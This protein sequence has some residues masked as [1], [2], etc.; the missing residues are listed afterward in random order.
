MSKLLC[1]LLC[2]ILLLS[3]SACKPTDKTEENPSNQD[4][5]TGTKQPSQNEEK[6]DKTGYEKVLEFFGNPMVSS[7]S[8]RA[9]TPNSHIFK[10]DENGIRVRYTEIDALKSGEPIYIMQTSDFH[11]NKISERD[12]AENNPCITA[13][14]KVRKAYADE[15]TV[16]AAKKVL[17]LGDK[18]DAVAITG[19][20]IDYLTWGSLDLIKE[21]I[22]DVL[23]DKVIM[24][25]GGHDTTRLMEVSGPADPTTLESRYEILQ[26]AWKHDIQY[27]NKIIKDRVMLIQ[28]NNGQSK[29]YEQQAQKLKADIERAR[30][31]NLTILIFQHEPIATGKV[32]D[33]KLYSIGGNSTNNYYKTGIGGSR[34]VADEASAEVYKLITENADVIKGIF[35]GH[36]HDDFYTEVKASYLKDG[37]KTDAVIPQIVLTHIV[38][39]GN[40]AINVIIVE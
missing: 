12:I 33:S 15:S 30:K 9:T 10:I 19:D 14:R 38:A 6:D 37:E 3:F 34:Y 2:A 1:V 29:Y 31:E 26:N 17:A 22:W 23:G 24:P 36:M 25:L 18:F 35:C 11:F 40:G 13:T 7:V 20:N 8:G 16:A 5:Q 32:E 4:E 21:H 39:G 27:S 28:I